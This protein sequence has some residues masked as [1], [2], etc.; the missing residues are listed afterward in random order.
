MD[1]EKY[2]TFS[3]NNMRVNSRYYSNGKNT[4]QIMFVKKKFKI[5]FSLK[6]LVPLRLT[7]FSLKWFLKNVSFLIY[8]F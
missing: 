6:L 7:L 8:Y 4:C 1:G 2:C 5:K 3:D